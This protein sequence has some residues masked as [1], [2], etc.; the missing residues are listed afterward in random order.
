MIG[1]RFMTGRVVF[2]ED[3]LYAGTFCLGNASLRDVL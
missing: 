2:L 3:N 1:E